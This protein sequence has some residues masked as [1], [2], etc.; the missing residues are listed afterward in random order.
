[1]R[2]EV[3]D[4]RVVALALENQGL[5]ECSVDERLGGNARYKYKLTPEGLELVR[6]ILRAPGSRVVHHKVAK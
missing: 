3:K 2:V 5:V 6:D 4:E 1:M